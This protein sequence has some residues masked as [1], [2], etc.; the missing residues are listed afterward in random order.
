MKIIAQGLVSGDLPWEIIFIGIA[1]AVSLEFLGLNSL[2]VA[3]GFYLPLSVS[4]PIMI[5]GIVRWGTELFANKEVKEKRDRTGTLFAFGLIAGEALISVIIAMLIVP[6]FINPEAPV[7]TES[8]LLSFLLFM[9]L[10]VLLF[11]I[12]MKKRA[13]DEL[14]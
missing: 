8:N 2:T 1:L 7:F 11:A 3:V 9:V 12:T 14:S 10:A 13:K 5:G 4:T 6:G